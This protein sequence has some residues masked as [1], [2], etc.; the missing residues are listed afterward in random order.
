MQA[1]HLI[2]KG[3]WLWKCFSSCIPNVIYY[4]L[5]RDTNWNKYR[6]EVCSVKAVSKGCDMKMQR[7]IVESSYIISYIKKNQRKSHGYIYGKL[8]KEL[9]LIHLLVLEHQN[10][11]MADMRWWCHKRMKH[12]H[13]FWF[14]IYNQTLFQTKNKSVQLFSA[15]IPTSWCASFYCKMW[16]IFKNLFLWKYVANNL[17]YCNHTYSSF[18]IT[19]CTNFWSIFKVR[20]YAVQ[21]KYW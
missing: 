16:N 13:S 1:K 14:C 12:F 3:F 15:L 4:I 8:Q 11:L 5:P 18:T 17:Y 7:G 21:I 6:P 2:H 20:L 19:V 9:R 10:D